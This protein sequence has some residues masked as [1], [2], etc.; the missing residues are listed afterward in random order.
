MRSG[1]FGDRLPEREL[2]DDDR[3]EHE[4]MVSGTSGGACGRVSVADASKA[5]RH[6]LV[7]NLGIDPRRALSAVHVEGVTRNVL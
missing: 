1:R 3:R 4:G 7:M 6:D 5:A 2:R